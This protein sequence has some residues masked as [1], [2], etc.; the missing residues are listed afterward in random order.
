MRDEGE[1]EGET[2]YH[3]T[4]NSISLLQGKR[5]S[6]G[7]LLQNENNI[8]EDK[9]LKASHDAFRSLLNGSIIRYVYNLLLHKFN[10]Q[11]KCGMR[12]RGMNSATIIA[13]SSGLK[14]SS[15]SEGESSSHCHD[16]V[17]AKE[18]LR[19]LRRSICSS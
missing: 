17:H 2:S 9:R 18:L 6:T 11:F 8:I 13:I 12:M 16:F 7:T 19:L 14:E 5:L 10:T 15:E 1:D 3:N 4:I